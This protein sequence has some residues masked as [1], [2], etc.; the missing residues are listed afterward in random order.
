[1][2]CMLTSTLWVKHAV[3]CWGL[4]RCLQWTYELKTTDFKAHANRTLLIFS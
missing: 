1:M 2:I 3:L 4:D